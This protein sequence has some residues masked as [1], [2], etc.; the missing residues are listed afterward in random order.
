[1]N[2]KRGASK[3][4]KDFSFNAPPYFLHSPR[5]IRDRAADV[6]YL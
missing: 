1:M 4:S 5:R 6:K 3:E 2:D